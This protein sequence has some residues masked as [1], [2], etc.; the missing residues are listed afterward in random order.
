MAAKN[1]L[2]HCTAVIDRV[3]CIGFGIQIVLGILW[4]YNAFTGMKSF[5]EGIVCVGEIL[6]MGVA[7]WYVLPAGKRPA[8]KLFAGAS[9]LTFPMVLQCFTK[10]DLRVVAAA[11]LLFG[12]GV[13][14]RGKRT[15]LGKKRL[16]AVGI[17]LCLGVGTIALQEPKTD[18]LTRFGSRMIW[19]TLYL[20]YDRL[21]A[22][23]QA[24]VKY[25]DMV[26]ATYEATGIEE[27]LLPSLEEHLG[28]EEGRAVLKHFISVAWEHTKKQIVKE[29]IWD[30][31]AYLAPPVI[32]PLQLA[33]RAYESYSG[34]NYRQFLQPAPRLG[35]WFMYYGCIWFGAALVLRGL[36]FV[37]SGCHRDRRALCYVAVTVFGMSLWYTMS[38][39]GK[40][41]YRNVIYI[42]CVWLL[43]M[44]G[45]TA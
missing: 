21:P 12:L 36:R 28:K 10:P 7:I 38:A 41:D 23:R 11:F 39:G 1:F 5:G 30:E 45:G 31:A 35:S 29:I 15:G 40:M 37:L 22:E 24:Q 20:D 19:T 3:I 32:L 14:I 2:K 43:W 27:I 17:L 9:V 34:L 16:A 8:R 6:L 42:L 25:S 44:A 13:V 4:M 33:G 26:D 18:L